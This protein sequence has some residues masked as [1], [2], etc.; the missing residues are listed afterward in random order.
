MHGN[1][2]VITDRYSYGLSGLGDI[3]RG[4]AFAML[5]RLRVQLGSPETTTLTQ[6]KYFE[7]SEREIVLRAR[8]IESGA[9]TPPGIVDEI[10]KL[11]RDVWW[12][13]PVVPGTINVSRMYAAF[14]VGGGILTIAAG[15]FIWRAATGR[16]KGRR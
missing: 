12:A 15:V 10:R 6:A 11:E 2:S 4:E 7:L 8:V 5:D 9:T 1:V 3:Q 13:Q 14:G 16:R